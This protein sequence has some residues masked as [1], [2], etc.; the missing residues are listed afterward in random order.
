[1]DSTEIVVSTDLARVDREWVCRE[2]QNSYWARSRTREQIIRS[3]EH[4]LCFSL[5]M[6]PQQ[7]GFARVITDFSTFAYLCDV[8]IQS[9]F[10]RRSLGQYLLRKVLAD[11]RLESVKWL[12]RT[13][14]A[15]GLYQKFG[16]TRTYRPERYMER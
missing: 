14:D 4:S 10:R 15:H 3:L 12:L 9:E 16:F 2:I 8:L 1:M 6:G 13:Q 7:V 11:P 5:L